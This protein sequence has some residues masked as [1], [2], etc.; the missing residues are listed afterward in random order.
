TIA[1][2]VIIPHMISAYHL[3]ALS[4][5]YQILHTNKI[6]GGFIRGGGR[7]VGNFVMERMMDQL[8]RRLDRDPADV[9]RVN[10]VRP[11]EMPYD[12]GMPAMGETVIYDGGDYPRLLSMVEQELAG[13]REGPREDGRV[14]G[15][16]I[17]CCVE[18][19][20]FGNGEP[21][22]GRLDKDG[23]AR[24]FVGSTPQ[25]QGH[26][27]MAAQVFAE[28]L[29]WPLDRVQ[30][31]TGDSRVVGWALLTAGSRSAVMVGNAASL[32]GQGLRRKLLEQ[33]AEVLEADPMDLVMED[34]TISVRGAP[35][36]AVN[37]VEVIPQDG[38]E[39]IESFDP[40][41]PM[42]YPSSC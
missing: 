10:L 4:I 42:T 5:E 39:A 32:A 40:S 22:R 41:L 34:G 35:T 24:L 11:D 29:G 27:T 21:G 23:T 38:L 16:G 12:T 33:A 25:G 7:P 37:A 18:S 13:V 8:A 17:V 31:T 1:P 30:V 15:R 14:V 26:Q 20:S 36:R 28:R 2:D 6:H 3:P 19:S 9:R